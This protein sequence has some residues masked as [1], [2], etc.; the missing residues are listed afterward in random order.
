M[1][2]LPKLPTNIFVYDLKSLMHIIS[3]EDLKQILE[4]EFKVYGFGVEPV[5][6]RFLPLIRFN[7]TEDCLAFTL[8]Y[9][10]RY[11]PKPDIWN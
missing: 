7:S 11:G 4:D 8:K 9:G 3:H 5:G 6:S 1:Q 10:H 2:V